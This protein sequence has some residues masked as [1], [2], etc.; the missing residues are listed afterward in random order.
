[1]LSHFMVYMQIYVSQ[2]FGKIAHP[3][4]QIEAIKCPAGRLVNHKRQSEQQ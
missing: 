4:D 3:Y 1:M 2:Q